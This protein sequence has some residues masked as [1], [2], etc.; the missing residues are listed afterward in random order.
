MLSLLSNHSRKIYILRYIDRFIKFVKFMVRKIG[1]KIG[2]GV[3]V[4]GASIFGG[5]KAYDFVS[6]RQQGNDLEIR[7]AP[8]SE[9]KS[10]TTFY[11]VSYTEPSAHYGI[12][13]R[14][15]SSIVDKE[16]LDDLML[17]ASQKYILDFK[18]IPVK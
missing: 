2:I 5:K 11:Q 17:M 8:I 1:T 16:R 18:S 12:Q 6:E 10:Q 15:V 4:L 14:N 3:L 7:T 9:D 13:Q